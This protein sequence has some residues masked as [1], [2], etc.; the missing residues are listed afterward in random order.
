MRIL[1]TGGAGF[2][3]SALVRH[4]I[5]DTAHTVLNLDKLT[6]AASLDSLGSVAGHARYSFRACDVCDKAGVGDAFRSYRP[7][8]VMHL[9]AETHVDRSIDGPEAFLDT[10]VVGTTRLLEAARS[11]WAEL[12]E[13][14]KAAFRFLHVSTDEV[15]GALGPQDPAFT[16]ETRYDPRSPYSASKAASDHIVRAWAHTYGLPVVVANASNNYGPYQFPEKLIPLSVVK[17]LRGEKLPVYGTGENVRD[18]L[19]VEDHARALTALVENARP[20]ETYLVGGKAERR[21][22]D[23]VG[24]IA[25]SVD[26]IVGPLPSGCPRRELIAFVPDRPGHDFRYAMNTAKIERE[27]GWRPQRG[28]DD[29]LAET[30]RWYVENRIWWEPLLS[31]YKGERLGMAG[32]G[33]TAASP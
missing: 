13:R 17:A 15:F 27:L 2:I 28:F 1:V 7:E 4:L 30:V 23:V 25:E 29:A 3:G 14:A 5:A 26:R 12:D 18:W 20:G 32:R 24:E 19:F 11:Y 31:R 16:E 22:I 8:A 6:Y 21:N 10:N 9:A 33:A